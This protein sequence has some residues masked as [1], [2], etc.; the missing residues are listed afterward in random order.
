[1]SESTPVRVAKRYVEATAA[2]EIRPNLDAVATLM[3]AAAAW[4]AR[5]PQV[6]AAAQRDAAETPGGLEPGEVWQDRLVAYWKEWD[7]LAERLEDVADKLDVICLHLP[8]GKLR[9]NVG[10]VVSEVWSV[11]KHSRRSKAKTE[12]GF[13]EPQFR[14][15]PDHKPHHIAYEV[16]RLVEWAGYFE[17]WVQHTTSEVKT[18]LR[19]R[20]R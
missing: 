18:A 10:M 19:T 6:L 4:I 12:Y 3:N 2:D 16:K 5:F 1:M 13:Q 8:W 11:V 14:A 15:H 17:K 7:V 9:E 20:V